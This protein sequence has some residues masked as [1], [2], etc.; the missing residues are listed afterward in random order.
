MALR[1]TPV[2]LRKLTFVVGA[3][4]LG[5]LLSSCGLISGNDAQRDASGAVTASAT[6]DAFTIKVGDCLNEP[7]GTTFSEVLSVPC[8]EPHDLEAF[9]SI[10]LPEGDFPGRPAISDKSEEFCDPK[11]FEFVGI[12]FQDSS[13]TSAPFTPTAESWKGGDREIVCLVGQEKAKTTGTLKGANK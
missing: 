12:A 10:T 8:G 1:L 6:A 7:E 4:A 11:F 2:P 13:L 5:L 9:A 3:L